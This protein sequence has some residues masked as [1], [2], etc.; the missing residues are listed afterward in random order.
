MPSSRL[1]APKTADIGGDHFSAIRRLQEKNRSLEQELQRLTTLREGVYDTIVNQAKEECNQLERERAVKHAEWNA[2]KLA[3]IQQIR[4][5]LHFMHMLFATRK[6]AILTQLKEDKESYEAHSSDANEE[7]EWLLT[8]H[9]Q[10]I[11]QAA[12][13]LSHTVD[14]YQSTFAAQKAAADNK[15]SSLESEFAKER[16]ENSRLRIRLETANHDAEQ[17]RQVGQQQRA[18]IERLETLV[19]APQAKIKEIQTALEQQ[20]NQLEQEIAGCV[21]QIANKHRLLSPEIPLCPPAPGSYRVTMAQLPEPH[22]SPRQIRQFQDHS[23]AMANHDGQ[24][25]VLPPL[26]DAFGGHGVSGGSIASGSG[27]GMAGIE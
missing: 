16:E 25:V 1:R 6:N 4:A 18:E 11:K 14:T 23:W 20:R 2:Q 12:T 19:A 17:L 24:G 8:S 5:G 22:P 10:S 3:E 9:R 26:V 7:W 13:K 15:I 27:G 21:Q